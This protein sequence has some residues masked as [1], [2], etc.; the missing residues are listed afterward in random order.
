MWKPR[1][2]LAVSVAIAGALALAGCSASEA[3][4]GVGGSAQGGSATATPSSQVQL[5]TNVRQGARQVP[6]DRR[7]SARAAQGTLTAVT[8]KRLG[9]DA[10]TLRGKL[11]PGATSWRAEHGLLQASNY[12]LI[13]EGTDAQGR[14]DTLTTRFRTRSL[15]KDEQTY[16]NFYPTEGATVGVGMPIT[17]SFDVPVTDKAS[18]ERHL[19]V[20]AQPAQ[21]GAFH[22]LSDTV[23]HWRPR[24]Y[25][26]PGTKVTV[27]ADIGGVPA[28]NGIYGQLDRTLHF[29][30]GRSQI[31]KV[32]AVTHRMQ[33]VRDGRV[34]KNFPITTGKPGHTTRSG[35]KVISEKYPVKRM[36]S[37]TVGI[38]RNS[39]DGYDINDVRW[40][41]RITNSGE[42]IHAAPWSVGSQGHA[43][44]SHGCTGMSTADA[45]WLYDHTLI[46][47]V[48]EFTGTDR[49]MTLTNGYGD[50]NASFAAYAEGSAL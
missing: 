12:V 50:W 45:K 15:T 37:E 8:L 19:K 16:P 27:N 23:V 32:N 42:F 4:S 5:S 33:V 3:T 43:N 9:K 22:W 2:L 49:P 36:D 29:T 17:I 14:H 38:P 46:G 34:I 31:V 18:I 26:Q 40:A 10:S 30:I 25:W 44:V 20:T 41:M 35:I 28:G 24:K 1:A 7:V 39:A 21:V 11:A 6:L 47:D 13:V 48:T